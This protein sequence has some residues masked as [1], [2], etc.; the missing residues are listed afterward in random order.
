[1]FYQ[2][3]NE[4]SDGLF[5]TKCLM[6]LKSKFGLVVFTAKNTY[7]YLQKA[8]ISKHASKKIIQLLC[9]FVTYLLKKY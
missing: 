1:M 2:V 5:R 9:T 8:G 4:V 7:I 3:L 6:V